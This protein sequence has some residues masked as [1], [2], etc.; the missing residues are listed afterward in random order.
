MTLE[1]KPIR[2]FWLCDVSEDGVKTLEELRA[3]H[4]NPAVK[5]KRRVTVLAG[6][7]NERVSEILQSGRITEAGPSFDGQLRNAAVPSGASSVTRFRSPELSRA[8][9]TTAAVFACSWLMPRMRPTC[10]RSRRS[11]RKLPPVS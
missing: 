9:S 4:T 11:R 10:D 2:D 8:A 3:V 7:F 1:P 5:P 6:D